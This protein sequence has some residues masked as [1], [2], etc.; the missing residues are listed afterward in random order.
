MNGEREL[1]IESGGEVKKCLGKDR[2]K[3]DTGKRAEGESTF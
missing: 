1:K 2:K 3:R